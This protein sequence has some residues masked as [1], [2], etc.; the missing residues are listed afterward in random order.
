MKE[1][2]EEGS[3]EAD[4]KMHLY[5]NIPVFFFLSISVS[6]TQFSHSFLSLFLGALTCRGPL[7]GMVDLSDVRSM[8]RP[9]SPLSVFPSPCI[10]RPVTSKQASTQTHTRTLEC[11]PHSGE[12]ANAR[13][14]VV[15][16]KGNDPGRQ[17]PSTRQ[18]Q[19]G[20]RRDKQTAYSPHPSLSLFLS[21]CTLS[22][23]LSVSVSLCSPSVPNRGCKS[24]GIPN[25]PGKYCPTFRLLPFLKLVLSPSMTLLAHH[26]K[27]AHSRLS[28]LFV[29]V[30]STKTFCCISVKLTEVRRLLIKALRLHC[31]EFTGL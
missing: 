26:C 16:L 14:A 8:S 31:G 22:A 2:R 23:C 7:A 21:L 13:M 5:S 15:V 12:N 20:Q 25:E 11:C 3:R 10:I 18:G 17:A 4:G 28:R 6:F 30:C 24:A 19:G 29:V 9:C 27:P 1:R